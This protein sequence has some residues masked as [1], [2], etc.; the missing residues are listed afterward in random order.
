[1]AAANAPIIMKE[2]LT[3]RN[4]DPPSLLSH[5]YFL[6]LAQ[7]LFYFLLNSMIHGDSF[8][9]LLAGVLIILLLPMLIHSIFPSGIW[10]KCQYASHIWSES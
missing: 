3:V 8:C 10:R 7:I 9:L 6:A 2:A 4:F 1:M 5:L